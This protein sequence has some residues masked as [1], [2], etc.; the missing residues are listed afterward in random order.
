MRWKCF[1]DQK[2][3]HISDF[4]NS[5]EVEIT[6][7]VAPQSWLWYKWRISF[8]IVHS[9]IPR[10]R[11]CTCDFFSLKIRVIYQK[12]VE[13]GSRITQKSLNYRETYGLLRFCGSVVQ[14]PRMD[15]QRSK[16]ELLNLLPL[17][18]IV[19]ARAL[20]VANILSRNGL[21]SPQCG[22]RTSKKYLELSKTRSGG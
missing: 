17:D 8:Q 3:I 11:A 7:F 21:W 22:S 5:N 20:A 16:K 15:L 14:W 6:V 12:I 4:F 9:E 13:Q 19:Q 10:E 2:G 1:Y 18:L